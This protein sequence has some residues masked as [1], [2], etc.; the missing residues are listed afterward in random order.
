[1]LLAL[2]CV[3]VSTS[4]AVAEERSA[5]PTVIIVQGA[6]G[7]DS[8]GEQFTQW[9]TRWEKAANKGGAKVTALVPQQGRDELKAAL[10]AAG[11]QPGELWLVLIGHGTYDGK[12]AR[13]N[14]AGPDVSAD[15]LAAWLPVDKPVAVI[16]CASSSGPFISKLAVPGP[17][18]AANAPGTPGAPGTA[19]AADLPAM[20]TGRRIVIT[21]TKSG[22]EVNFARFGDHL[23]RAIDD[24]AADLDKDGQTSLLEAYLLASRQTQEWYKEEN[25]LATEHA[26]I[27]DNGDGQGTPA[28]FFRG[29]RAVKRAKEGAALD[30]LR[31][32]QWRL[33]PSE[34]EKK[35]PAE[36][37]QKRDALEIQIAELRERRTQLGEDAYYQQL[38][39]LM[40][41]LSRVYESATGKA[42]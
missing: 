27:D 18:A 5:S 4:R 42:R 19:G 12:T 15:E 29:T 8:F 28:E 38:E 13:F 7:E 22:S 32:A 1:M 17:P 36:L 26:L 16:N 37:R 25:R 31:A 20:R 14:L 30:G 3:A 33:V 41:E 40:L 11:K 2:T 24:P 23:S 10:D 39:K 34:Q 21:A 35:M 9:R 6:A